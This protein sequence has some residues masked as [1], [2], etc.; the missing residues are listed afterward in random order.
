MSV[1]SISF[2]LFLLGFAAIGVSSALKREKNTDDYLL[3]SRDIPPW[4]AALSAVAT[5]NSGFMFIGLIGTTYALGLSAAWIMIGWVVGDWVMWNFVHHP[6]RKKSE[7]RDT[8]T[9][10]DFLGSYYPHPPGEPGEPPPTSFGD[11][12]AK[13]Y[14][15]KRQTIIKISAVFIVLFLGSYAAAQ[16]TAG[17]KALHVLFGWPYQTGAIIGAVIVLLYCF[18]G[19]IRASIWTDV[20][21][22]I[23]M[24]FAMFLLLFTGIN[25]LGGL[26]AFWMQLQAVSPTYTSF[27]PVDTMFGPLLF[28]VGWFVAGMGV[29]GQPH[30]MVRFMAIESAESLKQARLIYFSWYT[31]FS[32][33]AVGVG[34]LARVLLPESASFDAELSLPTIAQHLLPE[35][36]VG[37]VMAGLFAA[38]MSTADSQVLSCSAALTQDLFPGWGKSYNLTKLGTVA[39]TAVVLIIA[40]IGPTSVFELVALSWAALAACFGPLLLVHLLEH[41]TP[42]TRIAVLMMFGGLGAILIWRYVLGW[43]DH[44]YEV[45]PGVLTGFAIYGVGK[46]LPHEANESA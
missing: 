31:T 5:N 43:S 20:A 28:I 25:S 17:S 13:I 6:L 10:S 39:V 12:V 22:S 24:I 21:Q 44:I 46:L 37:L 33:C 36:L 45:L 3:A 38:T 11:F 19:G 26:E 27:T 42:P 8:S 18:S 1:T 14:G 35:V 4:M 23:V 30:I 2:I 32:L 16:L 29:I 34:L 15:H 9:F 7:E 41:R 40:L